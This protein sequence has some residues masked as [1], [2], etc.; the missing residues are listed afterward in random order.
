[1]DLRTVCNL[2]IGAFLAGAVVMVA[3][4]LALFGVFL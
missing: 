3:L 1:M 4:L 2:I